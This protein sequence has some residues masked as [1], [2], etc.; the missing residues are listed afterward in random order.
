[1][2][3]RIGLL[4]LVGFAMP[5]LAAEPDLAPEPHLFD[6]GKDV[7]MRQGGPFGNPGRA[8]GILQESNVGSLYLDRF[9]ILGR[10]LGQGRLESGMP[11]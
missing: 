9:K 4:L 8:A 6:V 11:G 3:A 7:A 1:M 2:A 10:A 5:A